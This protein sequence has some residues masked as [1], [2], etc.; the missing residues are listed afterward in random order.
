MINLGGVAKARVC[1]G[2]CSAGKV[3][4]VEVVRESFCGGGQSF[5]LFF[6][7]FLSYNF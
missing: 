3:V 1:V 5:F 6:S 2:G 4:K 7:L